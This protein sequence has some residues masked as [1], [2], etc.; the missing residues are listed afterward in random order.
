MGHEFTFK[1]SLQLLSNFEAIKTDYYACLKGLKFTKSSINICIY[2]YT[3][4]YIICSNTKKFLIFPHCVGYN[5]HSQLPLTA[6]TIYVDW[7]V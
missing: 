4:L 2:V 3:H 6:H 5:S 7:V 1:I